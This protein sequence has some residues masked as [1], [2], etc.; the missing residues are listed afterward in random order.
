MRRRL[1]SPSTLRA[2]LALAVAGAVLVAVGLF[3]AATVLLVRHELRAS[4]DGSL[5][6]RARQVAEL[7]VFTPAVL[8]SPGALESPASGRQ[9]AVEV[10]DARGRILARSVTLGARLL[11]EDSLARAALRSGAAGFEDVHISGR[12]FRLYAAPIPDATGPASGGAVLVASDTTDIAS[13]I[14]HLGLVISLIGAGVCV[15]AALAAAVLTR[16]GLV[17]LRPARAR[18]GRDRADRRSLAPAARGPGGER[19]DRRADRRA[20]PD[21]GGARAVAGRGAT[22]PRR[23]LARAPHSRHH[24]ARQC[25]VRRP[26]RSR[27]GGAGR[28]SP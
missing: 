28:A 25:R 20:Q 7:A 15:L 22:V 26:P 4:L 17:P 3:A 8:S 10:I 12:Q 1:T 19:G 16:R 24:A 14:A 2:R 18:R 23:R 27:R 9:L 13:T 11:P 6:D 5:R 21:A